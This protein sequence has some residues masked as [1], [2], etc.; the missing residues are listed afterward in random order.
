MNV[1]RIVA[2]LASADPSASAAFYREIFGLS[3]VMNLDW[4]ATVA[5]SGTM[6]PQLSV[7]REGGSGT[8]VPIISIEVADLDIVLV[9]LAS[10]GKT[11]E[12]GPVDEP[13]GVRRFYIRDPD[14]H[15]I[16]VLRHLS[17]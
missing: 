6:M 11:P 14:G 12:Y 15:L 9:R 17:A 5:A 16:N 8:A 13:W 7:A 3:E 1:R 2:N 10:A 4:I